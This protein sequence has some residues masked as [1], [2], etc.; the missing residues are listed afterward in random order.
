MKTQEKNVSHW[1]CSKVCA[2]LACMVMVFSAVSQGYSQTSPVHGTTGFTDCPI[3]FYMAD[4]PKAISVTGT[5]SETMASNFDTAMAALSGTP[6]KIDFES[7]SVGNFNTLPLNSVVLAELINTGNSVGSNIQGIADPTSS[8]SGLGFNTTPGGNRHLQVYPLNDGPTG[9][10]TF[11][12]FQ[13]INAFGC[14]ISGREEVKRHVQAEIVYLDG[15]VQIVTTAAGPYPGGGLQFFGF[16]SDCPIK[17]VAFMEPYAGEPAGERDIYTIDDIRYTTN[18]DLPPITPDSDCVEF[19]E[20]ALGDTYNVGDT[21]NV[22]NADGSLEFDVQGKDFQWADGTMTS[23]GVATVENGGQAGH[24]GNEME[25][26]NI[27]LLFHSAT[28][29]L[30][31]LSIL[32]GEYGGNVNLSVNGS[33]IK[34]AG[35]IKDLDGMVIGGVRVVVPVGGF[36]NDKGELCLFAQGSAISEFAIGGQEFWIDHIC[37]K[38]KG[39]PGDPNDPKGDCVEFEELALGDTY[40]VGDTFNVQNAD[41]SLE[42]D[43][44]GKDFQWA[45]GTM[46]SAGVATVENGGQAGHHGNEMET[47]NINLLFHSATGPLDGLSILFG[48]YGGNVNLSVNGSAIKNAGNI[49][50]LDGMVIGGVRV[51]VPVG[52]FGNDKGELCLFAQGSAIS[53]FAIGGQEFWIDHICA[54]EKG[55]PGDPN[56]PKDG[57]D[58]GDLPDYEVGTHDGDFIDTIP[59]YKTTLA[60]NGPRHPIRKGLSLPSEPGVIGADT[61]D[62]EPDGQPTDG[63]DGDDSNNEDDEQGFIGMLTSQVIDASS[64]S[65]PDS[66]FVD[67]SIISSIPV[68]NETGDEAYFKMFADFNLNGDFEDAGELVYFTKVPGDNSVTSLEPTFIQTHHFV[69]VCNANKDV[70][71]PIRMRLSTDPNMISYGQAPDGEV[72]DF[73]F[74]YQMQSD[75]WCP[76]IEESGKIAGYKNGGDMVIEDN[77]HGPFGLAFDSAGNLMIANEGRGGGGLH[78]SVADPSGVVSTQAIGFN[79]PSGVAYNSAGVLHISDDSNRVFQ[80]AGDGTVTVLIDETKG[81]ANP[82][83]LAFDSSDNL[84]VMSSGGFLTRFDASTLAPTI[85]TGGYVNSQGVVIS[86]SENRIYVSEENGKVYYI[87]LTGASASSSPGTLFADTA[88]RTEGGLIRDGAGNIYLSAYD[89]G[90]VMK[91]DP[92]GSVSEHVTG[93][94]QARGLAFDASGVL[95]VTSYDT[96]KVYRIDPSSGAPVLYAPTSATPVVVPGAGLPG[97]KIYLDLNENGTLDA[98][99]PSDVTDMSGR[100]EFIGLEAG[101]YKVREVMQPGWMQIFPGAP[102]FQHVV[103]L[104]ADEVIDNINFQNVPDH[105]QLASCVEFEDL[106]LG[107][108]YNVG[109]TFMVRDGFGNPAYD[110]KAI[111]FVWASGTATSAGKAE[112]ENGGLAGHLGHEVEVNNISLEFTPIPGTIPHGVSLLFG[113]YGGNLNLSVNGVSIV[114]FD[115]FKD[116]DGS[117]I[118]GATI[119]VISGGLGNDKGEIH[120]I[121]SITKFLLGGQEFYIDHI[122]L[123][124]DSD[125]PDPQGP[126]IVKH[127]T[128]KKV[129]SGKP[130]TFSIGLD[131]NAPELAIQWYH[132][133]EPIPGATGFE[134]SI[135]SVDDTKKGTYKASASDGHKMEFS[136]VAILE[137]LPVDGN[138]DPNGPS[139]EPA[140]L[141]ISQGEIVIEGQVAS[142]LKV[143]VSQDLKK[144]DDWKLFTIDDPSGKTTL[145]FDTSELPAIF[146][147]VIPQD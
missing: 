83:A 1:G 23:A 62:G 130:V 106:T 9:G 7:F 122:C 82:N 25:T 3:T 76:V 115:N 103:A 72:V 120:I 91:I 119:K 11:K 26:N 18:D 50:D 146:F 36:G 53:E 132:N 49:K 10:V 121:G 89:T 85:I 134:L 86:E 111:D 68:Q 110:V 100:Y 73:L 55:D 35:N 32:F 38:E 112:V 37:A 102:D 45:D 66:V 104:A 43:V 4:D 60:D 63:A 16:I 131:Q 145:Q 87:T 67:V 114:N 97:W 77:L 96:D 30:D 74:S 2:F 139:K 19:E 108:I 42:F 28:G 125:N 95:Y 93:I 84:Y 27:N 34:N 116:I 129:H 136:K 24:H 44:Q 88:M 78:V 137:V 99:E 135:S 142:K 47:N 118:G 143:Q 144:W 40:N 22:K 141:S 21:F 147:R 98:G 109:D 17:E 57:I 20:L 92:T 123:L 48:E 71:L 31:G 79:G 59:D 14:Y 140:G 127:P 8:S 80:V 126:W 5:S 90:K 12:F 107:H 101:T 81:L 61:I 56:D 75:N 124:G 70:V 13:P 54:K 15:R 46:T 128:D 65:M 105:P 113:E 41:G 33:A 94:S 64:S 117:V 133:E 51:V 69:D 6:G 39:D 138:G 29:P 58:F 52:G